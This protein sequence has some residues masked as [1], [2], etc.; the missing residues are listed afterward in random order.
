VLPVPALPAPREQRLRAALHEYSWADVGL[1]VVIDLDVSALDGTRPQRPTCGD[2]GTR[3]VPGCGRRPDPPVRHRSNLTSTPVQ[4][5]VSLGMPTLI[6]LR[7]PGERST[8]HVAAPWWGPARF[9]RCTTPC[10]RHPGARP[11]NSA[12]TSRASRFRCTRRGEIFSARRNGTLSTSTGSTS[13]PGLLRL[14]AIS[15]WRTASTATSHSVRNEYV[16]C[17]FVITVVYGCT[18]SVRQFDHVWELQCRGLSHQR[19]EIPNLDS[20]TAG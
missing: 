2:R 11:S 19:S 15:A 20:G 7:R 1:L 3:C 9:A 12:S 5:G 4:V 10:R 17:L 18:L 8:G 6:C 16:S 13:P 14:T